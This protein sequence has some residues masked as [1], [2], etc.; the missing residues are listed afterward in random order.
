MATQKEVAKTQDAAAPM[1]AWKQA[2]SS[3]MQKFAMIADPNKAKIEAGF[4]SQIIEGSTSLQKIAT[5]PDGF[6][7]II[8]CI[9]NVARMGITLNPA[10]KLAY[11]IP[12]KGKCI[13]DPSWMGLTK[14]LTDGG[15]VKYMAASIVYDDE[16]FVFDMVNT[17]HVKKYAESEAENKQRRVVGALSCAVL[18]DNTKVY[19]FIPKWELDKIKAMSDGAN[20][21]YSPYSN[22]ESEMQKKAVIRRHYKS[23][24]KGT[25]TLAAEVISE[26]EKE[27]KN[28]SP[29]GPADVF[30]ETTTEDGTFEEVKPTDAVKPT[31]EETPAPTSDKD[32]AFNKMYGIE[33]K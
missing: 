31:E 18:K 26:Q 6:A 7:S 19:E 21:S 11:L 23:L 20:S 13:L 14:I 3:G 22:W 1:A 15:D 10:M 24:P 33:N 30:G 2:V 5:T 9:I 32:A 4:A 16:D 27:F 29:K 8:N 17:V 28:S 12:R 25:N